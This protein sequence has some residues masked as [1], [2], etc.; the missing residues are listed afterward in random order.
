MN[1]SSRGKGSIFD[2]ED[3]IKQAIMQFDEFGEYNE[4]FVSAAYESYRKTKRR[5][6]MYTESDKGYSREL[7]DILDSH[8]ISNT[9]SFM[10][11]YFE[12]DV[13]SWL[14]NTKKLSDQITNTR[15]Q[16]YSVAYEAMINL[17]QYY[18]DAE[19]TK[20][21]QVDGRAVQRWFRRYGVDYK[22][23]LEEIT[24]AV[25]ETRE[26]RLRQRTERY[27][28]RNRRTRR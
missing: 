5:P 16:P 12:D 27:Q 19:A 7:Y 1:F 24:R 14:K 23:A 25:K 10:Q 2:L 15:R 3:A 21:F 4:D 26:E 6:K 18:V 8:Y 17:I 13:Y 28:G 22:K 11:D 20:K 9:G